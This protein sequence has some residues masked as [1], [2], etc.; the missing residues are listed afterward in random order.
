[1]PFNSFDSYPMSWK[2]E[3]K[4]L[5]HPLFLSI[6]ELLE[7][8]ISSGRLPAQ[9]KLPPQREL[10]DFLDV[11]LSTI[12]RAF[13][14]CE[15]KGLIY[16]I[17]GKGTFVSPSI[18]MPNVFSS[19]SHQDHFIEMG[20]IRP[21]YQ[22]NPIILEMARHVV[23]K[24]GAE[25]LFEYTAPLGSS[26]QREA[27]QKW[28]TGFKL[29]IPSE[30][31][32]IVSGAQN[33]LAVVLTSLFRAGDKIAT[34]SYTH[35]NFI[36]LA[37]MLNIQLVPIAGDHDGMMPDLLDMACRTTAI[38][39][40]YIM[41]SY[42]NPTNTTLTMARRK[43]LSDIITMHNLILIEDDVYSFLMPQHEPIFSLTP[44]NS[45]YIS[46]TS[47]SLCA[48]LR[49]AFCCFPERFRSAI[50]RGVYNV[51]LKT[52]SMNAEII[53]EI[54][55]S[56]AAQQIINKKKELARD[57][58]DIFARCFLPSGNSTGLSFFQWIPLPERM[59][60]GHFE[61]LAKSHGVRIFCSDRFAVGETGS[62]AFARLAIASPI[63]NAEL[64]KGLTVIKSLLN[65]GN[66][67]YNKTE[68]IV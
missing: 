36:N 29:D 37:N 38:S 39:G 13:K 4:M 16:A 44:D 17:T 31:I 60:G 28:L 54:I 22:A 61:E 11:N 21:F 3:R 55:L 53:A 63:D 5:K 23:N 14:S 15:L 9:T 52:S 57:R 34:D 50:V 27:A 24:P 6:A 18:T 1:M 56:G 42:S 40:V 26:F 48:G 35:P 59:S 58:N 49:V 33:A 66:N 2:P 45:I 64:E 25:I 10:A 62:C 19:S 43:E 47:K 68:F 30:N 67:I 20:I 46:S 12:T 32:V 51:N 65:C 8:D 41:P 7:Q